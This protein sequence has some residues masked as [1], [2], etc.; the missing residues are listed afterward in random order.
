MYRIASNESPAVSFTDT[1]LAEQAAGP[2][3][4][5]FDHANFYWR[6]E[7][8]PEY[9]AT[10]VNAN[11]IG[12]NT[13]EMGSVNYAGMVL[14]ITR[15]TG[16]GQEYTI[17]SN[18]AT[19]IT[20]LQPWAVQPDAT[21]FFVVTEAGWHF[22]AAAKTS[23]VQF[24]VPNET[25]V[26]LQIQG[27]AANVNNLEGS[28]LL[29][30]LT[31][32]QV[33]GGGEGDMAAP[34]QPVFGL[35]TSQ[36]QGGTVE[37]SGVSF[38]DLTNTHSVTA[39]TLTIHYWDELTGNPLCSLAA[40]VVPADTTVSLTQAG[41]ATAGAFIQLEEEV[42]Q[43]TDV[44]N[45]GLQYQ[46]T[47]AM[48]GTTADSHDAQVAVYHLGNKVSVVP[49]PQNFFGSPASGNWSHPVAL[50]N[51]KVS[52]A[53]LCVTNSRGN[54]PTQAVN[55]TKSENYGLRT[56]S[57]GQYSFQ[58]EGFLAVTSNPAPNIVVEAAHAVQDIY[59]VVKQAP[60]GGPI[61]LTLNQNGNPYCSL[62]IPDGAIASPSVNGFGLVLQAQAQLSLAITAVGSTSPGAD[63]TV[64]V[65]L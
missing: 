26:T 11:T 21:S 47:R 31:R 5:A 44:L 12:N 8:Q 46:V 30:T 34:P 48:H 28:A 59:A 43:V 39:G 20:L 10:I 14:R 62:T 16:A 29:S 18:T 65:R 40:A 23:P 27:R 53:E 42:L 22:A 2:P 51:T 15:G 45:G 7:L 32:W 38:S 19:S 64:I 1:G 25:G 4:P 33:G 50:P 52:S 63:L 36:L 49:F 57:G 54:S 3:D 56:L 9:A 24:A 6:R 55:F 41:T 17:A 60:V 13:A 37:L 61:H 35:G 58:V